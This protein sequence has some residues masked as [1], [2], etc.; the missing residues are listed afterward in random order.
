M[1]AFPQK[2][3]NDP[4]RPWSHLANPVDSGMDLRDYF[5]G[6]VMTG[7]LIE[8]NGDFNDQAIAELAYSIADAM[9][10]ARK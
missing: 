3:P 7:L 1:K 4:A 8:A 2:Y 5:A 6:Q 10:D 9:M